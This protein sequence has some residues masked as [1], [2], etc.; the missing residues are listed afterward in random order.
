MA[1]L[2]FWLGL[3]YL[4]Q[5]HMVSWAYK[6]TVLGTCTQFPQHWGPKDSS[7]NFFLAFRAEFMFNGK[8]TRYYHWNIGPALQLKSCVV[9]ARRFHFLAHTLLICRLRDK[10]VCLCSNYWLLHRHVLQGYGPCSPRSRL[11]AILIFN[12]TFLNYHEW[13]CKTCSPWWTPSSFLVL[14][15]TLKIWGNHH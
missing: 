8:I 9:T 13:L 12:S 4:L 10:P 7:L 1:S 15:N 6:N 11:L 2:A 5:S 3:D 14:G